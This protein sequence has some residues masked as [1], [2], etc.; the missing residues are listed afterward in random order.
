V[1][2]VHTGLHRPDRRKLISR[3]VALR[4]G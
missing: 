4:H 2:N 1:P 3:P